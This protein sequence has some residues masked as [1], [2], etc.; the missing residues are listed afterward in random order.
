MAVTGRR[1]PHSGVGKTFWRVGQFFLTKTAVTRKRKVEKWIQRC[2][3]DR[4]RKGYKRAID[5]I[6]GPIAKNGSPFWPTW[7]NLGRFW[8]PLRQI[9]G[10][11]ASQEVEEEEVEEEVEEKS[12]GGGGRGGVEEMHEWGGEARRLVVEG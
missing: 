12:R 4:L 5:E 11:P 1:C 10:H 6:R 8:G 7:V 9:W 3:I 2:Q